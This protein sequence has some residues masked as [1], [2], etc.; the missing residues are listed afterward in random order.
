MSFSCLQ[1]S[2]STLKM[3]LIFTFAHTIHT[4]EYV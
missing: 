2:E 1:L 3:R 4:N